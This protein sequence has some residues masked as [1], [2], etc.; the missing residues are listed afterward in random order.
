MYKQKFSMCR[1]NSPLYRAVKILG[2]LKLQK[3]DLVSQT[4]FIN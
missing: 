2:L 4:D 3:I 1:Q